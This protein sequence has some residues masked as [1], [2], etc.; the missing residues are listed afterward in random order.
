MEKK[1]ILDNQEFG[2]KAISDEELENVS[3]GTNYAPCPKCG[4]M[5]VNWVCPNCG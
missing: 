2:S 5:M 1:C 3:G 4:A